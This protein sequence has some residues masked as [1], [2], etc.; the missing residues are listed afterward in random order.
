MKCTFI[1]QEFSFYGKEPYFDIY[2]NVLELDSPYETLGKTELFS[3]SKNIETKT[4]PFTF[5][6][7]LI[8]VPSDYNEHPDVCVFAEVS[9]YK[10]LILKKAT[11][12]LSNPISV[13]SLY[14]LDATTFKLHYSSHKNPNWSIS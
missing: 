13:V 9:I 3:V 1:F 8:K 4:T 11:S 7:E 10:N 12:L 6:S 2:K 5:E 14:N